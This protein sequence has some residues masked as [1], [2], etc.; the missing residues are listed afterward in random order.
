MVRH[1]SYWTQFCAQ[2]PGLTLSEEF[3]DLYV[4]MLKFYASQR[5]TIHE[6]LQHPWF[7][8][9]NEMDKEQLENIEKKLREKFL[10][11]A[12]E[13]KNNNQK[14]EEV[15]KINYADTATYR[16]GGD[17]NIFPPYIKPKVLLIPIN[18]KY[19]IKIIGSL[20]PTKFMNSLYHL[21]NKEFENEDIII[22]PHKQKLKFDLILNE[23]VEEEEN[24][25]ITEEII[26][27]IK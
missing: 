12:D 13:I 21:L 17:D 5:P 23:E 18:M 20:N 8:E 26:K 22:K 4:K 10:E 15:K 1:T 24:E 9:I 3:K 27:E 19:S 14:T 7:K 25:E 6:V 11:V 2:I 16:S